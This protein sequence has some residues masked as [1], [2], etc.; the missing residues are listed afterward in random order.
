MKHILTTIFLFCICAYSFA[1]SSIEERINNMNI[2]SLK[3]AQSRL[4][5]AEDM[6]IGNISEVREVMDYVNSLPNNNIMAFSPFELVLL[7]YW[8]GD[9]QLILQDVLNPDKS[10]KQRIPIAGTDARL[11]QILYSSTIN[12]LD[13]LRTNIQ[14]S[15]LTQMEKDFLDLNLCDIACQEAELDK[16]NGMAFGFL[17]NYPNSPFDDVVRNQIVVAPES[18]N[19]GA[20]LSFSPGIILYTD[21]LRNF[22]KCSPVPLGMNL[23]GEYKNL[24]FGI[25]VNIGSG[26]INDDMITKDGE[27]YFEKGQQVNM[28]LYGA[29]AGYSIFEN[30]SL[31]VIPQLSFGGIFASATEADIEKDEDLRKAE[32]GSFAWGPGISLDIKIGG[33]KKPNYLPK[34]FF[35][36]GIRVQYK[37]LLTS[38]EK[39]YMGATGNMHCITVGYVLGGHGIKLK[40][41]R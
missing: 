5:I 38:L 27:Y 40:K 15:T 12:A 36:Q 34:N 10:Y 19:W 6:A 11:E 4:L 2:V 26:D 7:R 1:Q 33:R 9:Y 21:R 13:S 28:L 17:M 24:S 29:D 25:Y 18:E 41:L 14:V 23:G 22:R 39:K 35:Y 32:K 3:I 37:Y 8:L 16:L 31:K 30:K 20:Y